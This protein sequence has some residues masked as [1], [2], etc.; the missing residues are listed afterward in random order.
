MNTQNLSDKEAR[1]KIR[2][3]AETIKIAMLLTGLD[4]TP[5]SV[6]PMENRKVEEDGTIW[7][8][9]AMSSDHNRNI[10]NNPAVQILYS[11]PEEMLYLSIFGTAT[12]IRDTGV[13]KELYT[14]NDDNW[15]KGIHDPDLSAIKFSPQKAYYWDK[16]HNKFIHLTRKGLDVLASREGEEDVKGKLDM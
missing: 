4:E 16:Q 14:D 3:L 15:F 7:F 6:N 10:Q 12:I 2:D 1:L 5:I 13:L 11:H 8:L 9:S